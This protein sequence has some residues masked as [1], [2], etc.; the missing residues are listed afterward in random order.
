MIEAKD[1]KVL[2]DLQ[3][4]TE[5]NLINLVESL[6]RTVMGYIFLPKSVMAFKKQKMTFTA[7]RMLFKFKGVLH[8]FL[9]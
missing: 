8:A 2:K 4:S 3:Q 5:R 9:T 7:R 1:Y 6:K